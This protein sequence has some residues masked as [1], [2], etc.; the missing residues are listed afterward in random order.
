MIYINVFMIHVLPFFKM[1][2]SLIALSDFA[3]CTGNLESKHK[4]FSKTNK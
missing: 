2:T 3:N 4:N 1:E